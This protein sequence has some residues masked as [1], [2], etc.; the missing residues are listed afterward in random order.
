LL[1]RLLLSRLVLLPLA[2]FLSLLL[3]LLVLLPLAL[4]IRIPLPRLILLALALLFRLL[5]I[6]VLLTLALFL[7]GLLALLLFLL[8][9][10]RLVTR[11]FLL[12]LLFLQ[13]L[14]PCRAGLLFPPLIVQLLS[15]ASLLCLLTAGVLLLTFACLVLIPL[16][17]LT[18]RVLTLTI[19]N[20]RFPGSLPLGVGPLSGTHAP[21]PIVPAGW[22]RRR[23][24]HRFSLPPGRGFLP[25]ATPSNDFRLVL[26]CTGSE[27]ATDR[28][29]LGIASPRHAI[30]QS[31]RRER[32]WRHIH[33]PRLHGFLALG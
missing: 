13:R 32:L 26:V 28:L 7:G 5:T 18:G 11:R 8:L 14:L 6:L 24:N 4:L 17:L 33:T 12:S 21:A 16:L 27:H 3:P 30:G 2:L 1:I 10:H 19:R 25:F 20:L 15:L 9:P 23:R 22:R 29:A 31:V